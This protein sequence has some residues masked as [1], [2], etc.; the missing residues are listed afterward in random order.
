MVQKQVGDI[1]SKSN[2]E[3]KFDIRKSRIQ[4]SIDQLDNLVRAEY[5]TNFN[6]LGYYAGKDNIEKVRSVK[7]QVI[8]G[9]RGTGKTHLLKALQEYLLTD[10]TN[11]YI[12]I[13]IDMR[14]FK[15][16]LNEE[17]PLYYSL[18]ILKEI[19]IEVLKYVYINIEYLTKD[20]KNY[21]IN[22]LNDLL[23]QFNT[24]FQGSKFVKLG[25][26]QFNETEINTLATALSISAHPEF[27]GSGE[28]KKDKP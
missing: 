15:P 26:V 4:L 21:N 12:P 27:L 17:N 7:N 22:R 2:V 19:I 14:G 25:E 13:Y 20:N 6:F 16:L 8:Y 9:R 18:I 10:N 23:H 1:M 24:S 5:N 11:K 28:L 3:L